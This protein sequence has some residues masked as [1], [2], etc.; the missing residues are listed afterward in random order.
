VFHDAGYR[1]VAV[2]PGNQ[3]PWPEGSFYRFDRIYG[4]SQLRYGGP[5]F[6][7][8]HIPDQFSL[9]ALDADEL[10]PHPR[11]PLFVFFPTVSTH[12]PFRPIPPI[13]AD[14]SRML[15]AA[16]YEADTL[17][18][19]MSVRPEWTHLGQ[20][21]VAS[22]RYFLESF[23]LYLRHAP[24]D[25]SV[26]ILLGDHQPAASVTGEA[27]SWDVPVHV[28]SARPEILAALRT[29]GFEQGLNPGGRSL[30]DMNELAGWLLEAFNQSPDHAGGV[31][32]SGGSVLPHP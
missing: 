22:V 8:W 27:A 4:E 13:Q 9:E 21:Y 23:A 24:S 10:Q 5:Q 2:M 7:W 28:I 31:P 6:G 32:Q 1:A 14:W 11:Q 16:P 20:S 29:R 15:S 30:G 19:A 18:A 25:P 12:I 3:H 17:A 26:V